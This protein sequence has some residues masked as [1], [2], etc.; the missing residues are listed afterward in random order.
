[1]VIVVVATSHQ[2]ES[3]LDDSVESRKGLVSIMKCF[4]EGLGCSVALRLRR[5][6]SLV[7]VPK[8]PLAEE[9][10]AEL[11]DPGAHDPV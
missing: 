6:Q 1:M 8:L 5:R 2:V 10:I 3:G 7:G 11:Q 4:A 9:G